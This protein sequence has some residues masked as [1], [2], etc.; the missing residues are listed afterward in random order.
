M[1][2][3]VPIPTGAPADD[4]VTFLTASWFGA[5]LSPEAV[6]RRLAATRF[7]LLGLFARE[8]WSR[9]EARSW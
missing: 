8:A 9:P 4:A 1:T 5:G 3:P 6:A 7:R 2:L